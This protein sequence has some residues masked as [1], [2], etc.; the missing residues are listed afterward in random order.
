LTQK[1]FWLQAL[2]WYYLP[3]LPFHMPCLWSSMLGEAN[4]CCSLVNK[5]I[6]S[7]P[8]KGPIPSD[9]NGNRN[10]G[11]EIVDCWEWILVPMGI[12]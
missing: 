5:K 2:V 6:H 8:V 11:K 9:L 1:I 3:T 10:G 7:I 12:F 4:L